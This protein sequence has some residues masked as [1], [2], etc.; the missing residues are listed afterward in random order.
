[1]RF[2]RSWICAL[3]LHEAPDI[4]PREIGCIQHSNKPTFCVEPYFRPWSDLLAV[5]GDDVE[6]EDVG[7]RWIEVGDLNVVRRPP[8]HLLRPTIGPVLPKG[9]RMFRALSLL[10]TRGARCGNLH[11]DL[12]YIILTLNALNLNEAACCVQ[13]S[14]PYALKAFLG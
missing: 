6:P 7:R 11:L 4:P 8:R 14:N 5:T 12:Q 2:F 10:S 9:S 1:M 13:G 3:S